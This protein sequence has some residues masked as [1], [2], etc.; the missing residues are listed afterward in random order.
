MTT[1][2]SHNGHEAI[3][4]VERIWIGV[5]LALIAMFVI[6]VFFAVHTHGAH[7][8]HSETRKPV[9]EIMAMP[10]FADPGVEQIAPDQYR[11]TIVAQAFS[12]IPRRVEVPAGAEIEFRLAARDVLHGFNVKG[13]AINV[14]V[15]PGEVS[16][17]RYT[18]D[19]PGTYPLIC[20]QYCGIA[21]HDMVGFLT[22]VDPDEMA[23]VAETPENGEPVD[24]AQARRVYGNQCAA[25]HQVDG[26]GTPG[27]FPP[28]VG[29]VPALHAAEGGREYLID[30]VLYGLQG[31]I[32]V[33]GRTYR[34]MMPPMPRLSDEDIA[35]TLNHALQAWG[36]ADALP[37]DFSPITADEVAQRRDQELGPAD[38]L[39]QREAL[40]LD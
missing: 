18:F 34:G 20:N 37:G 23:V 6:L 9:D 14:E 1:D 27:T 30:I 21:H 38:V 16:T 25:C 39:Q 15:I 31:E 13:T 4:R 24:E 28:L 11:V 2:D 17:L 19:E 33:E 36:N 35:A 22:V 8:G 40:D 29:H 7:I 10:E 32:E 5:S 3:E 12:F 26:T